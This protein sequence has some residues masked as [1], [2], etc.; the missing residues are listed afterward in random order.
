[1]I[2]LETANEVAS[3]KEMEKTNRLAE[4]LKEI[5]DKLT[6]SKSQKENEIESV[7]QVVED[8]EWDVEDAETHVDELKIEAQASKD[9]LVFWI[10]SVIFLVFPGLVVKIFKLFD[11]TY[12]LHNQY[13]YSDL[14]IECWTGL[15]WWYVGIG[16]ISLLIYVV[17]VPC[18][19]YYSLLIRHDSLFDEDHYDYYSTRRQY[20]GVFAAY[21]A[22]YWY[23]EV[24]EQI[25]KVLLTGFLI[26]VAKGSSVQILV[27]EVITAIYL[28]AMVRTVPYHSDADD[29]LQSIA[30]ICLLFTLMIV[31]ALKT[32]DPD[33]P[34]YDKNV[35]GILLTILSIAVFTSAIMG[36]S[37]L[38]CPN[39]SKWFHKNG[40][41]CYHAH[42][43]TL[44]EEEEA[45]RKKEEAKEAEESKNDE[46]KK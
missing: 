4:N 21:E 22:D 26:I 5:N 32:D 23:W 45:A 2:E 39:I 37:I 10:N 7:K 41:T 17:G 8:A 36:I 11:C 15:H 25:K 29:L 43:I 42:H 27:A 19:T 28:L 35:M 12:I 24:I 34:Q 31:F 3:K 14:G 18:Y 9:R 38:F 20:G 1:V 30:S 33:K 40:C 46:T 13:L 16:V 44:E 6:K